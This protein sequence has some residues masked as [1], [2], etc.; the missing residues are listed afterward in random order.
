MPLV[1]CRLTLPNFLKGDV[2]MAVGLS[3]FAVLP[4]SANAA[5]NAWIVGP[6]P[7]FTPEI[8]TL[9]SVLASTRVQ[10]VRNVKGLS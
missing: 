4:V 9:T 2:G 3:T 1:E 7:G 5:E 10:V 8:G 6:Q